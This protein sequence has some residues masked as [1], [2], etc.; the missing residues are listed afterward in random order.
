MPAWRGEKEACREGRV[1]LLVK[2]IGLCSEYRWPG[3]ATAL[4]DPCQTS[5][6]TI[7]YLPIS[8]FGLAAP[9]GLTRTSSALA[10]ILFLNGNM[11]TKQSVDYSKW[12]CCKVF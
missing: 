10:P 11:S 5:S 2:A 6:G 7:H 1:R 3:L 8:D 9:R 4:D 12:L